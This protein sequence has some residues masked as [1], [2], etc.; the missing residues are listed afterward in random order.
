MR[1]S[2][3]VYSDQKKGLLK[4]PTSF[5]LLEWSLMISCSQPTNFVFII[6]EDTYEIGNA[7]GIPDKFYSKKITYFKKVSLSVFLPML[8]QYYT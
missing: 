7:N 1:S 3:S 6:Q 2:L 4:F 8:G 5:I